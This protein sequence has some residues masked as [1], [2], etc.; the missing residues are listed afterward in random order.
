M[1]DKLNQVLH[2]VELLCE[3]NPEFAATLREKLNV[4]SIESNEAD[5]E[6][7]EPDSFSSAMRLQHKRCGDKARTFYESILIL[8][9]QLY[10][11]LR[12]AYSNMLWYK[13]IFDVG[14]Y[15]VY[16]NYQIEN[17]LNY[18]LDHSDFHS[19]VA[20]DPSLYQYKLVITPTYAISLD[21]YTKAF[22]GHD[23]RPIEPAKLSMWDKILYWVIDTNQKDL[24]EKK[25]KYFNAIISVRNEANHANYASE[26]KS[27]NYW[28]Q[29][30]S[31]QFGYIEDLIKKLRDS[32]VALEQ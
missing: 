27:L 31:L 15:F 19:K 1:D 10:Q 22:D 12:N 16:V 6:R 5:V 4:E 25:K 24:L 28:Q 11:D 2:K 26:K 30:D 7:T 17:M 8:D 21:T 14:K 32:V 29:Q 13:S 18:Y 20:K 3:Q 9:A 23:N